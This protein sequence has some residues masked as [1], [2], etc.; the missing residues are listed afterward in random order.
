MTVKVNSLKGGFG[1]SLKSLKDDLGVPRNG[2]HGT[3]VIHIAS[4][5]V[6]SQPPTFQKV[7]ENV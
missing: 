5:K 1:K 4:Q 2:A 7:T 6:D 3:V